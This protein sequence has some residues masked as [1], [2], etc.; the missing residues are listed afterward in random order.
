M[1]DCTCGFIED[2]EYYSPY[3]AHDDNCPEQMKLVKS[4]L[5]SG[6]N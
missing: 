6:G 4:F 3:P 2:D 1:Y 5:E